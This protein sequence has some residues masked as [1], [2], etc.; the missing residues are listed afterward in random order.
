ML[1]RFAPC[2]HIVAQLQGDQDDI[3]ELGHYLIMSNQIK[4]WRFI[5]DFVN[6]SRGNHPRSLISH[7]AMLDIG[8]CA[9][10][11]PID[12]EPQRSHA[13]QVGHV[14]SKIGRSNNSTEVGHNVIFEGSPLKQLIPSETEPR[15]RATRSSLLEVAD[16]RKGCGENATPSGIKNRD[17]LDV[18][19]FADVEIHA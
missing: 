8:F 10:L 5:N 18:E 16:G 4:I 1:W 12:S 17:S 13:V 7:N 2:N 15:P 3:L 11:F 14:S 6:L 19:K 9:D